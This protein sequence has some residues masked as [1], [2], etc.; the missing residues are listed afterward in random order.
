[1]GFHTYPV[2]RARALDDPARYRFCSREELLEMLDPTPE[3]RVL[4]I[5]SGTGFFSSDVAPFVGSL[6]AVDIQSG[7]H[8]HHQQHGIA[9][10]I[11]LVTSDAGTLP[12]R[13]AVFDRAFSVD[14]TTSIT[15]KPPWLSWGGCSGLAGSSSRSTGR[16]MVRVTEDHRLTSDTL[17][18]RL[19]R[20][21]RRLASRLSNDGSAPRPS[22]SELGCSLRSAERRGIRRGC[23]FYLAIVPLPILG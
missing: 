6:I 2:A 16:R 23:C 3:H 11:H 17:R 4:D 22:R 21:W 1:M 13:D 5:G 20:N 14:P 19:S 18:A 12:F 8:H 7:M 15:L 10:N 9:V